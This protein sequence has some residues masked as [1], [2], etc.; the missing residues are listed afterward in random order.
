MKNK[1]FKKEKMQL[2]D[3][4]NFHDKILMNTDRIIQK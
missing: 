1:M 2:I 4:N 3:S